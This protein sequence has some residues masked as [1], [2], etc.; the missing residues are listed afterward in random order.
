MLTAVDQLTKGTMAVMHQVA[1]LQAEVSSLRK[2][3]GALSK[4]RR[5]KKTR[6]R[7]GVYLQCKMQRI[8]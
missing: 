1:L 3:N 6:V 7:L 4:R 2:A 5:A 8:Y